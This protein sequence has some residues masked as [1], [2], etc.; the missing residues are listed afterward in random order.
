M[1]HFKT[2]PEITQLGVLMYVRFPLSLQNV[3]DLL[4]ERSMDMC[5]EIPAKSN[6]AMA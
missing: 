5:D 4:H 3:E 2:S 1:P 6:E